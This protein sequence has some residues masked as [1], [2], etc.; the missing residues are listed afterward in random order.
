[1]NTFKEHAPD[2]LNAGPAALKFISEI[3][4]FCNG[5]LLYSIAAPLTEY[6]APG[7]I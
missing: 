2:L 7:V 1:M 4:Q 3:V 6:T 5:E